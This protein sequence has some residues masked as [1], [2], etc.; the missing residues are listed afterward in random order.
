MATIAGR[1]ALVLAENARLRL[2]TIFILYIAQGVP[3]GLFWF[4]IPT[5]MAANGA[6][7]ADIGYVLG[8]T[9]LPWTLKFFNGFIMDRYA[10]LQMGRRRPW[11]AGAQLVMI[12][13]LV[14]AALMQPGVEDV[15]ILAAAGFFIN[16]ATT[17]QD[18]AVDG[19]AVDIMEEDEQAQAGGMMFGGQ[20]IGMAV[21]TALTGMAIARMGP[22]AAYLLSA[23]FI[24]LITV[25][26]LLLRERHGEK[27]HP[28]GEGDTHPLNREVYLGAWWPIL[29]N[30]L[31]SLVRP[32]SLLWIPVLLA[33]GFHYGVLTGVTP[34]IGTGDVSWNEEQVTRL[35]GLAQLIAGIV[36]LTVGGWGG[37]I[38]GA[39]KSMITVLSSYLLLSTWM[40]FTVSEWS[41]ESHFTTFVY[42][43]VVLDTLMRVVGIP[44]SMRLCHSSVAA[45]QFALYMAFSNFGT[46]MGA[47]VLA[48]SD[49]LGGLTAMFPIIFTVHLVGL[50]AMLVVKYPRSARM[51]AKIA[52]KQAG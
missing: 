24:G 21:S 48:A 44:I 30:T 51:A 5:W 6:D 33:Q 19:L 36:G 31:G 45:T 28:W 27:T 43:W 25:Y 50:I 14:I 26:I 34:L 35:V 15:A 20:S 23:G 49:R 16:M 47:W 52:A 9:T 11:I 8:F 29:R 4:A 7:A 41:D 38:L 37:K 13:L 39:K 18:V 40:W 1:T 32:V 12:G 2:L 3:I 22:M 17:F 42:A 46:T 10:F